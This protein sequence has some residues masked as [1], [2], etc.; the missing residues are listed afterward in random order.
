M[1]F[2]YTRGLEKFSV[3]A[4]AEKIAVQIRLVRDLF[5]TTAHVG[6]A[7]AIA[8]GQGETLVALP[9]LPTPR[10]LP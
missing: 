3:A 7:D 6:T 1:F 5:L 2:L 4:V 8:Y 10:R 9:A